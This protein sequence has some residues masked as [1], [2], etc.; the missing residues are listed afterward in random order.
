MHISENMF[1]LSLLIVALALIC[2]FTAC[3]RKTLYII[4]LPA[5]EVYT[6][7]NI[8]PFIEID[9][10]IKAP[11]RGILYASDRK[12]T[13]NYENPFYLN[14]RGFLL[15]L[16][17]SKIKMGEDQYTME[18]ARRISLL[19]NRGANYPLKV[20]AVKE[21]G[22]LDRSLSIF[23]QPEIIPA[24]PKTS[25]RQFAELINLLFNCDITTFSEIRFLRDI[26][27][28]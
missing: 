11:Y 8:E 21:I 15:P 18:E 26:T 24:N 7:E 19:K 2:G 20:T 1:R 16:G 9:P 17:L 25:E 13:P 14:E 28:Y 5:P 10:N 22:I 3:A 6:D 23:T 27:G 4:K 12:P